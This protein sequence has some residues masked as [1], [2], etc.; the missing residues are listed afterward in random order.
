MLW[1][2]PAIHRIG[3]IKPRPPHT[4]F[5]EKFTLAC[6]SKCWEFFRVDQDPWNSG[7]RKLTQSGI[8]FVHSF[9]YV[10]RTSHVSLLNSLAPENIYEEHLPILLCPPASCSYPGWPVLSRPQP[11]A[12]GI[13][14]SVEAHQP[15]AETAPAPLRI[16]SKIYKESPRNAKKWT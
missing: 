2:R 5:E 15:L 16:R 6:K 7:F 10:R 12:V 14:P 1:M 11:K 8:V 4:A 9:R 3:F 13:Q